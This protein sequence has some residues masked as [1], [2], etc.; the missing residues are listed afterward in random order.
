MFRSRSSNSTVNEV[1]FHTS[2]RL[3]SIVRE[4]QK[5]SRGSSLV[6]DRVKS[7]FS[8]NRIRLWV[9]LVVGTRCYFHCCFLVLQRRDFVPPLTGGPQ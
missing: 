8:E 6:G 2:T 4:A 1:F 3:S 5:G 9:L 7:P